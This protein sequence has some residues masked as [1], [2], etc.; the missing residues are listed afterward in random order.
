MNND[1]RIL[2]GLTDLNLTFGSNE[3]QHFSETSH[4]GTDTVTWNLLLTCATNFK[5]YG[6]TMV[7]NGTKTVI[8]KGPRSAFKFQNFRILKQKFLC[9]KCGH[10][11]N[12]QLSDIK[13]NNHII[14]KV[15]QVV[16]MELSENVSQKHVALDNNVSTQTVM[17]AAENLFVYNKTNFHCLPQNNAFDEFK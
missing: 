2:L 8:H 7:N 14:D 16:A 12:A 9:K 1:I 6:N 4:N 11:S 10:T 17:R 3:E 13:P 15:K 5:K